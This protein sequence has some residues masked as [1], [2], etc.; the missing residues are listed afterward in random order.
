[1]M[2]NI[3]FETAIYQYP[4]ENWDLKKS[5]MKKFIYEENFIRNGFFFTDR[6]LANNGYLNEFLHIFRDELKKFKN[7]IGVD[8]L[9]LTDTWAVKYSTGDF[10]PVHTHSSTGYSGILYLD[11]DEDEHS[12]TYFVN[13]QTDPITDLTNYSLPAVHEGQMSIAPSNV[14]HFTFPNNSL[15]IRQVIGFDLKFKNVCVGGTF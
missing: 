7:D 14:L 15:K 8:E 3:M 10:H 6:K 12:G 5:E 1:M 2:K 11:Y 13:N 9:I 4:V